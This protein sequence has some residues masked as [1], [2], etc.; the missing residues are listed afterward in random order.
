MIPHD[1]HNPAHLK[2]RILIHADAALQVTQARREY[3]RITA[4][5]RA[6]PLK[7]PLSF[8]THKDAASN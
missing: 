8:R 1:A 2:L 7:R 3:A 4:P 5:R 6:S